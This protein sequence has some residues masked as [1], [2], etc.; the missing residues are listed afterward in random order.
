VVHGHNYVLEVTLAGRVDPTTGMV[1]DLAELKR[2]VG[3]TAIARFDHADQNQD[4]LFA[5]GLVPTTENLARAVWDLLAP[6]LGP[7]RLHRVRLWEDPT[8]YVEY[9]GP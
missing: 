7:D 4:P 8:F 3:E 1:V 9:F 5:G 2:L 6:K